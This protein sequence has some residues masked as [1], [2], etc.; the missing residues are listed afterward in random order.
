[1]YYIQ[2]MHNGVPIAGRPNRTVVPAFNDHILL[3][4]VHYVVMRVLWQEDENTNRVDIHLT[5]VNN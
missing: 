1:M 3:M 5:K 4:R 2:Y